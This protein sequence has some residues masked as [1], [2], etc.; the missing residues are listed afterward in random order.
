MG[1]EWGAPRQGTRDAGRPVPVTGDTGAF[2][3][4]DPDNLGLMLEVLAARTV[5]G[6]LRGFYGGLS[7]VTSS[8]TVR[9]TLQGIERTF[10]SPSGE[11]EKRGSPPRE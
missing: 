11:C 9:D 3:F 5:N 1:V 2:W 10:E 6:H 7:K 4:F 8:I